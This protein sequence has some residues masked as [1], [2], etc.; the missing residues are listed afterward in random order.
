V[1]IAMR[2]RVGLLS[3]LSAG[4]LIAMAPPAVAALPAFGTGPVSGS[5]GGP[6]VLTSI[7]VGHHTGFD[8]VVFTSSQGIGYSVQYVPQVIHDPKGTAIN[9]AGSAFLEV[10][11]QGT[12][13]TTHPAPQTTLT[14]SFPA[15]RQLKPAGEFEAVA[16]YGIGQATKAGF[17]AFTLTGPSRLVVDL[18]A[19][20][21]SSPAATGT[22][23]TTGTGPGTAVG[24]KGGSESTSTLPNTGFP[25]LPV[26]GLGLAVL[27]SGVLVLAGL[28]RRAIG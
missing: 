8:R 22:G 20:A 27:L 7:T 10:T 19:P 2:C 12:P 26:A 11:F 17:R 3:L 16:H 15:L 25:I 14:P 1:F 13:W 23:G 4:A 21:G 6:T 9:L 24:T 28:R 5:G 18:A